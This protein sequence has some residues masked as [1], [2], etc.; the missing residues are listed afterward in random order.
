MGTKKK[1]AIG[2][3]GGLGIGATTGALLSDK[4]TADAVDKF[5]GI[6]K[7]KEVMQLVGIALIFIVVLFLISKF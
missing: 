4:D 1:V 6:D 2:I 7:F 5:L 3:L